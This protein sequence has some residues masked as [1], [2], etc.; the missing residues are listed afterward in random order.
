MREFNVISNKVAELNQQN[1]IM[2]R[3]NAKL[4]EVMEQ[5]RNRAVELQ[6]ELDRLSADVDAAKKELAFAEQCREEAKRDEA[7]AGA[8]SE[9]ISQK[10]A[11]MIMEAAK[12]MAD[13]QK[14]EAELA[15]KEKEM[16]ERE[17]M[18]KIN[19]KTLADYNSSLQEKEALLEKR[20]AQLVVQTK[21]GA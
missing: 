3:E 9:K 14:K 11:E 20:A 16:D 18:I 5:G 12:K 7:A 10:S 2:E 21:L 4:A 6:K 17:K 15:A 19:E 8:E 13:A 1:E